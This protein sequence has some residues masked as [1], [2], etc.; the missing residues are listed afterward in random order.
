[1][2]YHTQGVIKNGQ[3]GDTDDT[4]Y[5]RQ[6]TKTN[7]TTITTQKTKKMSN[8]EPT[9]YRIYFSTENKKE[10]VTSTAYMQLRHCNATSLAQQ[11]AIRY[12]APL[13]HIVIPIQPIFAVIP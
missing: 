10:A 13:G 3:S 8:T 12:F 4:G 9:K 11:S 6:K 7:R 5:T 2:I 1:M